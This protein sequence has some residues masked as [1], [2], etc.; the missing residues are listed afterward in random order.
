MKIVC[1]MRMGF[2]QW[3]INHCPRFRPGIPI[4][5]DNSEFPGYKSIAGSR[6]DVMYEEFKGI[7]RYWN[8]LARKLG[9]AK[10]PG[11]T[12]SFL[13]FLSLLPSSLQPISAKLPFYIYS[14]FSARLSLSLV[15]FSRHATLLVGPNPSVSSSVVRCI[16][17]VSSNSDILE[18]I[19]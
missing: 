8:L 16:Q 19:L 1:A 11:I 3:L 14:P 9:R 5:I 15:F 7:G 12:C 13:I 18:K 2:P 17:G 6:D 4:G 10:P